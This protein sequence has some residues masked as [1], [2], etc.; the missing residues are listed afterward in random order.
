MV[1]AGG[2]PAVRPARR[3]AAASC[4]IGPRRDGVGDALVVWTFLV[5]HKSDGDRIGSAA[6]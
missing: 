3:G 6:A 2:P 1:R 4:A 5:M